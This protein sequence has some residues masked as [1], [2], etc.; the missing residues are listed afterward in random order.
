MS[1]PAKHKQDANRKEH[2]LRNLFH[3]KPNSKSKE[4]GKQASK[5]GR[6]QDDGDEGRGNVHQDE[7]PTAAA[8]PG[9][10]AAE[11]L[12]IAIGDEEPFKKEDT[13]W[14]LDL[15]AEKCPQ[16]YI[17]VYGYDTSIAGYTRVNKDTLYQIAMNFFTSFPSIVLGTFQSFSS[18]TRWAGW[19]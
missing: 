19:S 17:S 12:T 3:R 9:S 11:S 7:P 16:A 8:E 4:T 10:H 1:D 2:G 18:P 14:P 5:T 13:Y 6:S 15:L